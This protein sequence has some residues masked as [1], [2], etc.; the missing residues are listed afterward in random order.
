MF[1]HRLQILVENQYLAIGDRRA[2]GAIAVAVA[3]SPCGDQYRRFG[4]AVEVIEAA[5]T[6]ELF[7]DAGFAHVAPGHHVFQALQLLQW[8]DAQ[9]RRRQKGM[10]QLLATDQLHQLQRIAALIIPGYHQS[11]T[12]QQGWENIDQ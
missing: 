6:G 8:Q 7:D 3:Q 11:G 9:Q 12:L 2:K 10:A 5:L 1:G 4:R